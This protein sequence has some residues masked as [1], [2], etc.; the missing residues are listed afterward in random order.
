MTEF[1][2]LAEVLQHYQLLYDMGLYQPPPNDLADMLADWEPS[3]PATLLRDNIQQE[4][5]W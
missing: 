5:P 4:W 3:D 2:S 1:K